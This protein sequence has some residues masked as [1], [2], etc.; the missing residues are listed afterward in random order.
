ML[1]QCWVYK[2]LD[3]HTFNSF[4]LNKELT[5]TMH[6]LNLYLFVSWNHYNVSWDLLFSVGTIILGPGFYMSFYCSNMFLTYIRDL[7][8]DIS[9]W[10]TLQNQW[11]KKDDMC[12]LE[13]L[14]C[15]M[16]DHQVAHYAHT[17]A[18]R[19]HA[20][21][22]QTQTWQQRL[23]RC[24]FL[25]HYLIMESSQLHKSRFSVAAPSC[26][27]SHDNNEY[28]WTC[29]ILETMLGRLPTSKTMCQYKLLNSTHDH[30]SWQ[31]SLEKSSNTLF[32]H[33]H[34]RP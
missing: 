7:R 2:N 15:V 19:L 34:Q 14:M 17:L 27:F 29:S 3:K 25:Q 20:Y 24:D 4:H 23:H 10:W 12:S 13:K 31:K 26:V 1:R 11:L 6:F 18:V 9:L 30:L 8:L 32:K 16:F 21:D 22:N 5:A 33:P 28:Q